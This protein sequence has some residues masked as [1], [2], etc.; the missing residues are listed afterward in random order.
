[1]REITYLEV[2]VKL[3]EVLMSC[4]EDSKFHK[5]NGRGEGELEKTRLNVRERQSAQE[6]TR[7]I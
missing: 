5:S 1:M 4:L 6:N 2:T 3:M 7:S